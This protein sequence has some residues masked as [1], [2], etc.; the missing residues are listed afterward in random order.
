MTPTKCQA[1]PEDEQTLNSSDIE[2][3]FVN[4]V[5]SWRGSPFV[6]LGDPTNRP[7]RRVGSSSSSCS[8]HSPTWSL[9]WPGQIVAG[10]SSLIANFF[11][12]RDSAG[13]V[14]FTADPVIAEH[15]LRIQWMI[16]FLVRFIILGSAVSNHPSCGP[17]LRS[18][19]QPWM[20][21]MESIQGAFDS[22]CGECH[23]VW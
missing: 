20:L 9:H 19:W 14:A 22:V 11:F 6:P 12:C 16:E 18:N 2:I 4:H 5:S 7:V 3:P 8:P 17:S 21:R 1:A 10:S 23:C 13:V 15:Y